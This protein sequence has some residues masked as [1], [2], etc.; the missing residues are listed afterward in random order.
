VADDFWGTQLKPTYIEN[1]PEGLYELSIPQKDIPMSAEEAVVLGAHIVELGESFYRYLIP[2]NPYITL[3]SLKERIEKA[4]QYFSGGAFI[5]LGSRSPKDSWLGIQEGFRCTTADRAVKLLTD[6][7]ERV[8]DDLHAAIDH[9]YLPH[10]FV[11][12]WRDIPRWGELRCFVKDRELVGASQYF[13]QE[14]F[15]RLAERAAQVRKKLHEEIIPAL[16]AVTHMDTVV[17]DISLD[18]T[19]VFSDC[20]LMSYAH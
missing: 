20:I 10:I 18:C 7:S 2:G 16:I 14:Y 9:N 19:R 3:N 13:Y 11:R 8:S 1:W 6:V 15:P 5:R 17:F 12:Q 4:L